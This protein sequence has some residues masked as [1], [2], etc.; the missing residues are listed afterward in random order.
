MFRSSQVKVG[1]SSI[2]HIHFRVCILRIYTFILLLFD[3]FR[4]LN[5][6]NIDF[7]KLFIASCYFYHKMIIESAIIMIRDEEEQE[8]LIETI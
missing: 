1:S 4:K 5:Y 6:T 2:F 7:Y 8:K 3:R